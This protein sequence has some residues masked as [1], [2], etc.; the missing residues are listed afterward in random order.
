MT[1]WMD[2]ARNWVAR[3]CAATTEGKARDLLITPALP[4]EWG[5]QG[6]IASFTAGALAIQA[7]WEDREKNLARARECLLLDQNTHCFAGEALDVGVTILRE[8]SMLSPDDEEQI[9]QTATSEALQSSDRFHAR[10]I[11]MRRDN[12]CITTAALCD[13]IA[14]LWPDAD[15]SSDLMDRADAV[16]REWW[17]FGD[18]MEEAPNYEP[19]LLVPL[20]RWAER[21]GELDLLLKHPGTQQIIERGIEHVIPAGF[22]PGFGDTC[23][24]EL[25]QDWFPFFCLVAVQTGNGRALHAAEQLFTWSRERDWLAN[26]SITD[27]VGDDLYRARQGWSQIPRGAWELAL[28]IAVLEDAQELPDPVAQPF[29]PVVTLRDVPRQRM[30][31][32]ES[33]PLV[34]DAPG[35]R[36]IDKIVLRPDGDPRPSAMIGC[37]R[38]LWHDHV[39]SGAILAFTSG[40]DTLL[41]DNGYMQRYPMFHNLFW[42]APLGDDFFAFTEPESDQT[43]PD[44]YTVSTLGGLRSAQMTLIRGRLP[45]GLPMTHERIVMLAGEGVMVVH[46]RVVP[47]VDGLVGSP[48]WNVQ[49]VENDGPGWVVTHLSDFI[50]MNGPRMANG[51]TRLLIAGPPDGGRWRQDVQENDEPYGSP[52]YVEPVT[53]YF[54]YWKRSFVS[55]TCLSRPR[56]LV[57]NEINAFTT[58]LVPVPVDSEMRDTPAVTLLPSDGAMVQTSRGIGVMNPDGIVQ[59]GD[60][61][62]TDARAVW[63]GDGIFAHA[64]QSLATGDLQIDSPDMRVDIDLSVG[65][66]GLKGTISAVAETTVEFRWKDK[67][68]RVHVKGITPIEQ[69]W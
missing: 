8:N 10:Q 6:S 56:P 57:A 30:H 3:I 4:G 35:G 1:F 44:D 63:Y 68:A 23:T 28:G 64:V 18:N 41:D 14:R 46:D 19:L 50:G 59:S 20:F 31:S 47:L 45:H 26:L 39:D 9:R 67:H 15:E 13:A 65:A 16:W 60:W 69:A 2:E 25:W 7:R 61:G 36:V 5:G 55:R 43:D 17:L 48:L 51:D 22:V 54:T 42:A 11:G 33:W 24:M 38:R 34:P 66:D 37:S 21:R 62:T 29:T 52:H 53:R 27:E 58:L 49:H 40:G 12:H 32:G